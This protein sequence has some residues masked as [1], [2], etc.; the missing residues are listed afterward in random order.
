MGSRGNKDLAGQS[1][2]KL[3]E[4]LNDID[5]III[6]EYSMLSQVTFGWI[7][8]CCKQATGCNDKLFGGK[9]LILTSRTITTSSRQASLSC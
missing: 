8:K 2:C 5:Y 4:N 6:D 1:L 9:S 3:Q 7:D